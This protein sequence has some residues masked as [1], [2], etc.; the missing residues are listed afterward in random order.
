VEKYEKRNMLA[1][2]STPKSLEEFSKMAG[3]EITTL[4]NSSVPCR[5]V[6]SNNFEFDTPNRTNT[7]D[8]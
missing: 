3:G 2:F 6:Y 5:F 4:T 8:D 7:R 1:I